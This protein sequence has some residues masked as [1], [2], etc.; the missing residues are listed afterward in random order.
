[1]ATFIGSVLIFAS[2][3]GAGVLGFILGRRAGYSDGH[4]DGLKAGQNAGQV[5]M[6]IKAG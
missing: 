4:A 5:R 6:G 3:I 1:M 2:L